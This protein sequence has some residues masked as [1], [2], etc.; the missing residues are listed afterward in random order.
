VAQNSSP[1]ESARRVGAWFSPDRLLWGYSDE[2]GP[3]YGVRGQ[4]VSFLITGDDFIVDQW[5]GSL[6]EAEIRA[7]LDALVSAG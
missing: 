7:R 3:G 4:P 1:D 2:I 6:P 5:F